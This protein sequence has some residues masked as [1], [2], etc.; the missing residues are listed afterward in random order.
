MSSLIFVKATP[1]YVTPVTVVFVSLFTPLALA[2]TT[3]ILF[4]PEVVCDHVAELTDVK[5]PEL[6][7]E[8][9]AIC[10]KDEEVDTCTSYLT[11]SLS[12]SVPVKTR[13]GVVSVTD[14]PL[15]G[16]L[17]VTVG[18]VDS[19]YSIFTPP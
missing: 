11:S 3:R 19:L 14:P 12:I 5:S 6:D 9:T 2:P 13:S 1:L 17:R 15:L 4:D 10:P 7:V 16:L 8:S 18:A